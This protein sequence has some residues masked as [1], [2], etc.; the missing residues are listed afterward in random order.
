MRTT[1][2][3]NG[4]FYHVYN[5]GTDKRNIFSH[6]VDIARFFK[7]MDEFNTLEP[8]GSIYE[9]SFH[10]SLVGTPS[11]QGKIKVHS[12]EG[13]GKLVNFICYCINP[14]HYHFLL[15]QVVDRGIEKFLHRL[16]TGYTKY[17]NNKYKRSGVLFEGKFKAV[18][19]NTN[20]YLLHVSAY[21]NLND[22]VHQLGSRASKLGTSALRSWSSFKEYRKKDGL[23]FCKK[24][25]IL[26]QF[27]NVKAY[28][29]FA[30]SSLVEILKRRKEE[31]TISNLLLEY[32]SL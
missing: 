21:I 6:E 14:N 29:E 12:K 11:K 22:H 32:I 23:G 2:F 30:R 4:E 19:V 8:I 7:S 17:F 24:E 3:A 20:E 16:G 18:H 26:S 25:I 15:E 9:N 31:K 13:R 27:K 10:T 28:E 5:R 1:I